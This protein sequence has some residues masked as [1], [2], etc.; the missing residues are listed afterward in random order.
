MWISSIWHHNV[1]P[2]AWGSL[3]TLYWE[4]LQRHTLETCAKSN[5]S[6]TKLKSGKRNKGSNLRYPS[7]PSYITPA[8]GERKPVTV[9]GTTIKESQILRRDLR[10]RTTLQNTPTACH[11]KGNQHSNGIIQHRAVSS[12]HRTSQITQP[13][14]GIDHDMIKVQEAPRRYVNLRQ[15]RDSP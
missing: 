9:N 12:S 3:T 8:T 15:S 14:C 5:A 10:S 1:E 2:Q 4:Y 7:T 6:S 13:S 11:R